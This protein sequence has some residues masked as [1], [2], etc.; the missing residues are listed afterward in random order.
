M[1]IQQK[2]GNLGAF[3]LRHR[4][5]DWL[6]LQWYETSKRILRKKTKAGKDISLKFV[7]ENPNLTQDDILFEDEQTVIAVEVLPCD[8]IVIHPNSMLEMASV[9]YEIG[10]KHLPLY[11][12]NDLLLV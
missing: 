8:C 7:N 12:D 9:C 1:I 10:N 11:F 2:I 4:H 6:E 3:N 5:I